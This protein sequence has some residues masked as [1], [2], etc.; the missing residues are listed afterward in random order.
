MGLLPWLGRRAAAGG[1][2]LARHP[3]PFVLVAGSALVAW[4]L[5]GYAQRSD[6]FRI[7]QVNLPQDSTLRVP[8]SVMG[9]NLWSLNL[10]SL[11]EELHQQQPWLRQ[12]RVVRR[13][14][15]TV[16]ID[17]LR[18][19]PTAQV[20]LDRWYQVDGEGF[21]LPEGRTEAFEGLIRLSGVNKTGTL[22][23]GKDNSDERLQLALRVAKGI[24][25]SPVF[26]A[27]KLAEVNVNDPQQIRLVLD[28]ETEVRCGSEIEL[29]AHLQ[30][31][32]AVLKTL[33][34]QQL[35]VRYIDVR[36][37]EPVV[38]PRA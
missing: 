19:I 6:A 12:V 35:D 21:I 2:W 4:G 31:L 38:G 14:P 32:R 37:Q 7:T 10:R 28:G 16:R 20:K 3:Q 23:A 33:A 17:A 1:R 29:D 22:R 8:P 11:S 27:R 26:V 15:N 24:R 5:W 36:F 18:R 13:L 25:R 30:R 34:R 9:T